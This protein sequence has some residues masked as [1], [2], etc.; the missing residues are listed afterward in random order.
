MTVDVNGHI[1]IRA[2][3]GDQAKPTEV[4]L[5]NSRYAGK[6]IRISINRTF[7]YRAM[8]LGLNDFC[9]YGEDSALLCRGFDRQYVWMP[10]DKE[11]TIPAAEDCIRIE[12]PQGELAAPIPQP[13]NPRSV[14]PVSEPTTNTTGKTATNGQAKPETATGKSSRHKAKQQDITALIDQAIKFR[15]AAHD[16]MHEAGELAKALKQHR[17]QSRAVQQTLDQIRTLKGL[18]V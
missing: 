5:T 1:A 7:L 14:P 9:L 10:L 13:T 16:L 11:S 6:P 8:Q 4:V 3:P 2:K 17:R 18:G 15:T 12:S